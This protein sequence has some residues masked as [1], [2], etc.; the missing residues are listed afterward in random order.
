ME[1]SAVSFSRVGTVSS[2][3]GGYL[4]C[5]VNPCDGKSVAGYLG[6]GTVYGLPTILPPSLCL[7]SLWT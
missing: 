2:A 7:L 1:Y 6:M 5:L 3:V 4:G